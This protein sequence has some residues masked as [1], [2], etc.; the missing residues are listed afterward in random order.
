MK[1]QNKIIKKIPFLDY[2][3]NIGERVKWTNIKKEE[4]EGVLIKMNEDCLAT[5]RLD[6]G[7]EIEVQC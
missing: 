7:D 1:K 5:V 3:C 6:N 4:F 2:A